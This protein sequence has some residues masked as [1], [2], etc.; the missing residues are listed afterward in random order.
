MV[1]IAGVIAAGAVMVAPA[2]GSGRGHTRSNGASWNSNTPANSIS[3]IVYVSA[4]NCGSAH[5]GAYVG[6]ES[7]IQLFGGF[8]HDGLT[9]HPADFAGVYTYCR[10][11]RARYAAEFVFADPRRGVL[12]FRPA[13][14]SG[15]R[16][17]HLAVAPGDPLRISITRDAAGLKFKI[18]DV[19]TGRTATL[20]V[21][22][23]GI[24]SGWGAGTLPIFAQL[25]GA[26]YL[27]GSAE[28]VDEYTPS[29][30][31]GLLAGPGFFPPVV[32]DHLRVNHHTPGARTRG[33]YSVPWFGSRRKPLVKVTRPSGGDFVAALVS[34][35]KPVLHKSVDVANVSGHLRI[36]VPGQHGFVSLSSVKQIPNDSD[37]DASHGHIQITLG[38]AHG[39]S[40]TGVFYGGNFKLHQAQ[41]GDTTAQLQ[42]ANPVSCKQRFGATAGAARASAARAHKKKKKKKAGLWANAHGNFTTQGSAGAAAVLGTKWFTQNI[43]GGTYFHVTRDKIRV[44]AYYPT[45]HYVTVTQGHS[46][47]APGPVLISV[48]I[49]PVT[50]T[51][52]R[53]DVQISGSYSM[54]VVSA[55]RPSYVDAAVAPL[56]PSGGSTPFYSDGEVNGV[57]RWRIYFHITPNLSSFQDWNVG[58]EAAGQLYVVKLRV[59]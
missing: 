13:I 40:E 47:F 31:P 49:A 5:R 46:Y 36:H 53:Y 25:N 15:V 8:R 35:R 39:G 50:A 23:F 10:G 41:N 9:L 28:I 17:Q 54:T 2:S 4:V 21:P 45:K 11:R 6:Q 16:P 48:K 51:N 18:Y 27:T 22:G 24:R 56:P 19:N 7:G 42:G 26:P 44:T 37:I 43:C 34:I 32:F 57:P 55:F 58:I 52:G 38:L 14:V 33:V 30:G 12:D 3:A 59:R 20:Q 1:V 29:G